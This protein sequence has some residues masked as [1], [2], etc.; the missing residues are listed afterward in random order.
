MTQKTQ[1]LFNLVKAGLFPILGE[2]GI[3]HGSFPEEVDWDMV[4]R[5]HPIAS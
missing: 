3:V 4:Y 5:K 1:I 2:G